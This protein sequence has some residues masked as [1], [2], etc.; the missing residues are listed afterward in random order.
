[1]N[2]QLAKSVSARK[3]FSGWVQADECSR[4]ASNRRGLRVAGTALLAALV[5]RVPLHAIAANTDSDK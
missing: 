2:I 4:G 1:M 5:V 3:Q